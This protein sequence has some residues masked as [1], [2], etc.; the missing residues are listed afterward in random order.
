MRTPALRHIREDRSDVTVCHPLSLLVNQF[1]FAASCVCFF[2][3]SQTRE[4]LHFSE[5]EDIV[6]VRSL[7]F[8]SDYIDDCPWLSRET[9][10][11][12]RSQ[13]NAASNRDKVCKAVF[14]VLESL[15]KGSATGTVLVF[16]TRNLKY[17]ELSV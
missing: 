3:S 4:A 15:M 8:V 7:D 14:S 11:G 9:P 1:A 17:S 5:D 10:T 12:G 13:S 2:S 16:R 6:I